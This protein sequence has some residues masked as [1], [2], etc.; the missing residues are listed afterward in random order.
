MFEGAGIRCQEGGG[1]GEGGRGQK[2]DVPSEEQ[3]MFWKESMGVGGSG[4]VFQ[5]VLR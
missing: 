3:Q 2:H 4:L 1:S 5:T